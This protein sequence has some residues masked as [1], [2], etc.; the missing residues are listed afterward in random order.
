MLV[1]LSGAQSLHDKYDRELRRYSDT[2]WL[3]DGSSGELH[4]ITVPA[5]CFGGGTVCSWDGRSLVFPDKP[6]EIYERCFSG[7]Y[8]KTTE[9][10]AKTVRR[11]S[12]GTHEL[13]DVF[14][15]DFNQEEVEFIRRRFNNCLLNYYDLPECQLTVLRY[16]EKEDRLLSDEEIMGPDRR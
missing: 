1:S 2:D 11:Y 7:Q 4:R 15:A 9:N 6:E 13:L 10:G 3:I 8:E 16:D 12:K 14:T 5:D